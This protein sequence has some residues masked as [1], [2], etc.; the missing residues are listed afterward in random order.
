[1][2][3]EKIL[4]CLKPVSLFYLPQA[5]ESGGLSGGRTVPTSHCPEARFAEVN[6]DAADATSGAAIKPVLPLRQ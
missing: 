1:M 5:G 4:R 6:R 3:P 2:Q